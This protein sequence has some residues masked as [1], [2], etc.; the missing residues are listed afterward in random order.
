MYK[1]ITIC[2][3]LIVS[4]LLASDQLIFA[5]QDKVL[6]NTTVVE[7][8]GNETDGWGEEEGWGNNED[9]D[10]WSSDNETDDKIGTETIIKP[11]FILPKPNL[12]FQG[13]LRMIVGRHVTDNSDPKEF[14]TA[15]LAMEIEYSKR[16]LDNYR[17]KFVGTGYYDG[18]Y[19]IEGHDKY[20]DEELDGLELSGDINELW[21]L[22]K[23]NTFDIRAGRQIIVWGESDGLAI[24]DLINP[25]DQSQFFYQTLE[26]S[27][28]GL[29]MTRFNYYWGANTLSLLAI[30]EFR[31]NQMPF[32]GSEFDFRPAVIEGFGDMPFDVKIGDHEDPDISS[33]P[34][35]G[36]RLMVP[37]EGYDIS[38]M[39]ASIYDDEFAFKVGSTSFSPSTGLLE[40]LTLDLVH[41][42][43]EMYGFTA[44]KMLDKFIFK[45]EFAFYDDKT[46]NLVNNPLFFQIDPVSG[47]PLF[48]ADR[49]I[50]EDLILLEKKDVINTALGFDYT[51]SDKL[52]V[53]INQQYQRILDFDEAL[54]ADEETWIT[55]VNFSFSFLN[56]TL[57]PGYTIFYF[58]ND[59]DFIHRLKVTYETIMGVDVT[60]GLDIVD[61][62]DRSTPIGQ[63]KDTSR[64]WSGLKYSF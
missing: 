24:T 32:E 50:T 46:F 28:L 14:S 10:D 44:N 16:F 9:D 12:P 7:S 34:E 20:T 23:Q 59:K 53:I 36:I 15:K 48:M 64:I 41:K 33:H 58:G 52:T 31:P 61:P 47:I 18:V 57:N 45:V 55:F 19:S 49:N 8:L 13:F 40:E 51:Y 4:V 35:W 6:Q 63:Y 22:W 5:Q 42:R 30:C 29:G 60:I 25:R 27:R 26:D 43:F 21:L 54:L 56:D 62:S 2:S 38:L 17:F 37:K 3:G 11:P 1:I 39:A